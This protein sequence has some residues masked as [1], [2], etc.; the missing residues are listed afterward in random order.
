MKYSPYVWNMGAQ[1]F[2]NLGAMS[3]YQTSE[4]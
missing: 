1:F 3:Q 2:Q 4:G